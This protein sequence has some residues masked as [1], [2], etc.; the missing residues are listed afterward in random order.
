M[1]AAHVQTALVWLLGV[2]LIADAIHVD[3]LYATSDES[4]L[5]KGAEEFAFVKL[6]KPVHFFS[7]VYDSIYVCTRCR[8][9]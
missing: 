1:R 2:A 3:N 9:D 7:E 4:E 5:P 8:I 6:D